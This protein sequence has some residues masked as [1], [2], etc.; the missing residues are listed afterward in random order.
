MAKITWI[1]EDEL[2]EDGSG[3]S[4]N[5]WNGI[6][7]PKGEPVDVSDERMVAKARG[8]QFYKVEDDEVKTPAKPTLSLREPSKS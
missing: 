5:K 6:S 4:K 2:H 7:F 1:G 3:P 8:N